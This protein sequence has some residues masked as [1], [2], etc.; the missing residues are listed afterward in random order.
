MS[1]ACRPTLASFRHLDFDDTTYSLCPEE[2]PTPCP[3]LLGSV[4]RVGIL[5]PPI[6]RDTGGAKMR[7]VTGRRR[8]LAAKEA[9]RDISTACLIMPEDSS[10]EDALVIS[11]EDTILRG[12]VSMAEQAIFFSKILDFVDEA[13]AARRFLPLLGQAPNPETVGQLL[14]LLDLEER[15][16]LAVHQGVLHAGVARSLRG[17]SFIDRLSLFEAME[18]AGLPPADQHRFALGCREL[19]TRQG[20]SIMAVLAEPGLRQVLAGQDDPAGKAGQ[21]MQWLE[22]RGVGGE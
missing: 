15:L 5:H 3:A 22:G 4:G 12:N 21:L 1:S 6:L 17:L 14:E 7:I 2:S 9:R 20:S 16:L 11:L 19:A 8:M 13:H 18:A 10:E